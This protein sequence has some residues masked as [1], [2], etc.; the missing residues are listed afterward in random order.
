MKF[1]SRDNPFLWM[2]LFLLII[3]LIYYNSDQM[4]S[5]MMMGADELYYGGDY[6]EAIKQY[7]K[8]IEKYP[9]YEKAYFN[10]GL[11][12]KKLGIDD[13]CGDYK[14]ACDLGESLGCREYEAFCN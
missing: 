13:Y 6:E 7:T 4:R 14:K 1:F 11:S 5:D 10:R 3:G 12:K 8:V 9:K 2:G